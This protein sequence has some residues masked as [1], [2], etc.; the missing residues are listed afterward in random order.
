MPEYYSEYQDPATQEWTPDAGGSLP[1]VKEKAEELLRMGYSVR[2][3]DGITRE[4][5]YRNQDGLLHKLVAS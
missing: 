2:I 3:L 4:V 1:Y 5:L